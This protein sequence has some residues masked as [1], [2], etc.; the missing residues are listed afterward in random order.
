VGVFVIQLAKLHGAQVIA[1]ASARNRDLVTSLGANQVIDYR[2]SRFETCVQDLD[3][4]FDTVSGETLERSSSV[5][6]PCGR[7]VTVAST[8]ASSTDSRDKQAFFIVEPS[9]KQLVE[10]GALLDS[11]ELRTV[12]DTVVPLSEAPELY[13]GKVQKQCRGKLVVTV[14]HCGNVTN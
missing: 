14:K 12:V 10:V 13:A 5:L 8:A 3:V 6:K 9:E 4:V 11:G 1:T 2:E 7:M